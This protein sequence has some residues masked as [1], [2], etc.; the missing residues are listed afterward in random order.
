MASVFQRDGKWYLRVKDGTG[1]WV[2]IPTEATTKTEARRMAEDKA[3]QFE[4][5]FLGLDPL[6]AA[7]GG[8]ASRLVACGILGQQAVA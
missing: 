6:P 7:D 5:Q 4:R 1:R 2:K 8:G 3:R